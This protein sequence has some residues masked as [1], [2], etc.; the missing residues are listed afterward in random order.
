MTNLFLE[1]KNCVTA[2]PMPISVD[3]FNKINH[4]YSLVNQR[5]KYTSGIDVALN[6]MKSWLDMRALNFFFKNNNKNKIYIK[7]NL[8]KY[9]PILFLSPG[10]V[11]AIKR[12][13]LIKY[14][15]YDWNNDET[16]LLKYSVLGDTGYDPKA[17]LFWRHHQ[18]QNNV[19][20][21]RRGS[22][23]IKKMI[24]EIKCSG[25]FKYWE[26]NFSDEHY[27]LLKKHTFNKLVFT[28]M[29]SVSYF[30]KTRNIYGLTKLIFR[31]IYE[32]PINIILNIF[33][34][35]FLKSIY[36]FSK[37]LNAK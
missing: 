8:N 27:L 24:Q 26:K 14:G 1:N 6:F 37:S 36:Y 31:I 23:W 18:D 29:N 21:T 4:D 13:L 22:I 12:N 16:Q 3:E 7:K 19:I 10:G 32:C 34:R 35:I 28:V 33:Y 15:G 9:E 5:K 25:Y 30:I 2:A 20:Y 11:M 17:K